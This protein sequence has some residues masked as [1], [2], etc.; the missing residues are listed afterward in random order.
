MRGPQRL[1]LYL[2]LSLAIN[3]FIILFFV[4]EDKRFTSLI[5]L[6]TSSS[7]LNNLSLP[8]DAEDLVIEPRDQ[9]ILTVQPVVPI[10]P[11]KECSMCAANAELCDYLG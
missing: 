5:N 9:T 8:F 4:L 6:D 7:P 11:V 10:E 3:A 1:K 2:Y